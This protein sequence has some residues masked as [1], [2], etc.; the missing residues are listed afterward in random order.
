LDP[1]HVP[2][3]QALSKI[4]E[5][6]GAWDELV[7]MHLAEAEETLDPK[8]R[9]AA[10]ARVA[11]VLERHKDAPLDA[12]AH[13]ARA[14]S[15][16]PGYAPS[17]KALARLY[18]EAKKYR[19]LVELHERAVEQ[20]DEPERAIAHLFKI[21][22]IQE[23]AL[24]EHGQAA[25]TYRRILDLDPKNL[26]A[27]HALQRATERAGRHA[28][29]VDALE[30]EAA[31]RGEDARVVDLLTRAAEILDEVLRDRDGAI[32]RYRRVLE[33]APTYAPALS[34]LGRMYHR[35]GRWDDL[36][37]LYRRELELD[38]EGPGAAALLH[39]MG[40][41][42]EERIGDLVEA[43][44]CYRRAIAID[45]RHR[46]SLRALA[47]ALSARRDHAELVRVL[48]IELEGLTEPSARAR[49]AFRLG[50]VYEQ[51]LGQTDRAALA[52]ESALAA[53]PGYAPAAEALLRLRAQQGAWRR[54]V[55]QL[56]QE[57]AEASDPARAVSRLARAGELWAR[58]CGDPRR[59]AA[60]YERAL[61]IAPRHVE[62]LLALERLYR[63]LARHDALARIYGTLARV[64]ADPGAR[65]AAL[66]ELA[67]LEQRGERDPS[68]LRN[69][70]EAILSLSP[71]DP[72]ALDALEALALE[73]GDRALLA[74]VDRRLAAHAGDAKTAAAYQARLAESLEAAGDPAALDAY[75]AA[76]D[77][78]PQ[79]LAAAKGLARVAERLGQAE[80]IV[81]AARREAA[82]TSD[83][84]GAA[85]LLVRAAKYARESL[86][87]AKAA[88]ADLERALELWPDDADAAAGLAELLLAEGQAARAADRLA[89]AASSAKTPERVAAL[90]MEVARLQADR[91]DN[92]AG[93]LT[94]LGRVLK[95][96]PNHVPTL[97]RVA[98]LQVRQGRYA[99]AA[100]VLAQVV[101][102]APDREVLKAAHLEL[103]R[104][105][106]EH[107]GDLPRALVS[108][109]AVLA[110]DEHHAEALARLAD[111][112]ARSGDLD[113]AAHTLRRLVDHAATPDA[114]A[115]ALLRA[116]EIHAL[117]GD[118][119][120]AKRAA[121]EALAIAG[122][123][124]PARAHHRALIAGPSDWQAHAD[125]LRAWLENREGEGGARD[126]S[127]EI[128]RI[129]REELSRPAQA[130]ETLER[131]ARAHPGDLELRRTLAV[132]LRLSG[133]FDEA[134]AELRSLLAE[135]VARPELWRELSYTLRAAGDVDAA[136]RALEPLLL[137]GVAH[138]EEA[139]DARARKV[140]AARAR[141]GSLDASLLEALYPTRRANALLALLRLLMPVLGK[142]YPPDFAA[143][144]VSGRDRLSTRSPEPI[145]Q[146]CDRVAAIFGAGE[147]HL[148]P[149]RARGRGL[150]TELTS[151]PSIL[152]PVSITEMSEAHQA[153][154][155]ARAMA[156][157]TMGLHAIDK[158]TPRELE[159]V[160]AAAAR[161]VAPGF[162]AGLTGEDVL[163]DVG[164]RLYRALSRRARKD[165]EELARNY[166]DAGPQD[167]AAVTEA[168]LAAASRVALLVADDLLACVEV[169]KRTEPHLGELSGARLVTHPSV[170]RLVR[171]W[172]S[173]EADALR[174]RAGLAEPT[175]I[176]RA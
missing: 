60:C 150:A 147:V 85:R 169:L 17:F 35:A 67:R 97:R 91:L 61:E 46:P 42:C 121:L 134:I 50:E 49:A 90:W 45:P 37:E 151:P 66:R 101:S 162:G 172:V 80:A 56:E 117:R 126:A 161:R 93:A 109:Q 79:N 71:D 94:S 148:Y 28:E 103:A 9:A 29:L 43:T 88:I 110:L 140:R 2:T 104:I 59:A 114:R 6:A 106:A 144:G 115:D 137:L 166:V 136:R 18:A 8:R 139:R 128:A 84:R 81:E 96:S 57:A 95:T 87:D 105:Q 54:L 167:F 89:R 1:T 30:R 11:D 142:L 44:E 99:E 131:A 55:D 155:L 25:H 31:L 48:E 113:K 22:A 118:Q 122:P 39:K 13:H 158:L 123:S 138:G 24:G 133:R 163:D 107:L 52:Y 100:K 53:V 82:V 153:F 72:G 159:I 132:T 154:A 125:A 124:S 34:G 143:F 86:G 26:G 33:I 174:Q 65:V 64:L 7:A 73:R 92:V 171:F 141:P 16:V 112:A 175:V 98:E 130:I 108:L 41:L 168:V 14:L 76:L 149:H 156:N 135:S 3:L 47:R 51:H 77:S 68:E 176:A 160:L 27:L 157:I 83:P 145:R 78:D 63:K 62:S 170:S 58:A 129:Y 40:Q 32:A 74:R 120:A 23:D 12:M 5:A 111:V 69:L 152:V 19:E 102:L 70:F 21:G 38:P 20:A 10:H 119:E 36:L 173:P 146:T 75:R 4:Y 127:L 116:S 164:K 165:L 15:L